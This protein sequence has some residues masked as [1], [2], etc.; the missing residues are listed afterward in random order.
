[1]SAHLVDTG[2]RSPAHRNG[3]D[4]ILSNPD[5]AGWQDEEARRLFFAEHDVHKDVPLLTERR[6]SMTLEDAY[7]VQWRGAALRIE[8]GARFLGHKVGLTSEAMQHQVGIGEPDSG[9]LLDTMAVANGGTLL[10]RKLRTPR[11]EAEIAFLLGD[12]L[13]GPGISDGDAREAVSGVCVS[14]EV[15]DSRFDLAGITLADSVADNAGCARFVLGDV[16]AVEGL[17]LP[18][19]DVAIRVAG[20]TVGHG[21]GREVLGDPIRSVV[22]LAERLAGFG[23]GLAAGDIVLTGAVHGSIPL[24]RGESVSASSPHLGSVVLH[25]S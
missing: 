3:L 11:V 2:V 9:I 18:D 8:R 20:Q 15:I 21:R 25:V 24:P 19:E 22:W 14:L 1:M 17:N 13:V 5:L 6:P 4:Q 7:Q 16:V 12:D 10:A 23:A